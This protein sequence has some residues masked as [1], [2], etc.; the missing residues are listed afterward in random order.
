MAQGSPCENRASRRDRK[1][2]QLDRRLL[3]RLAPKST[4]GRSTF[5]M[6]RHSCRRPPILGPLFFLIYTYDL[7]GAVQG[8]VECDQFADDT[9][10]LSIHMNRATEVAE[11]Q[12]GV[13]STPR[14]LTEWRLQIN[15]S[16]TYV[17]EITRSTLPQGSL[18]GD[19]RSMHRK[20]MR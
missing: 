11:M 6:A 3:T 1:G 4:A 8:D 9:A 19:C 7:P 18:N 5:I 16:K 20:P 2:P 17:M 14:G 13:K 15:A 10:L 12:L